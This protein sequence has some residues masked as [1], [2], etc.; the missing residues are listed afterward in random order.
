M[1]RT[2]IRSPFPASA[3]RP[4]GAPMA[5]SDTLK[6]GEVGA[7][8][9]G[10]FYQY[11]R[12]G[13]W[14][15][16]KWPKKRG[17]P[18]SAAQSQAQKD[19]A[20]VCRAIKLTAAEVQMYARA[21]AAGTPML[22]RD[23]MMAAL[24]GN[25]PTIRTYS[26]KVIKPMANKLLSSTVLDAIAWAPGDLLVRG[27]DTWDP[28]PKGL[29]GQALM[30]KPDGSGL[31]WADVQ[32]AGRMQG[33]LMPFGG[34]ENGSSVNMRFLCVEL[35]ENADLNRVY[36]QFRAKLGDVI[37]MWVCTLGATGRV[38]AHVHYDPAFAV[39]TGVMQMERYEFEPA[40]PF[41]AGQRI[42]IVFS[43][44]GRPSSYTWYMRGTAGYPLSMPFGNYTGGGAAVLTVPEI[45]TLI[46][47]TR[48]SYN[49]I[50]VKFS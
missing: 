41:S 25:G 27:Q 24:Y 32:S 8:L 4:D 29:A 34:S 46:T 48:S 26:G 49:S 43:V 3:L 13:K 15:T 38:D 30:V 28:L 2:P 12:H 22:P 19:F 36:F 18:K 33:Y 45:N 1:G 5:L 40:L 35:L 10:Q 42:A 47:P 50:G 16:A 17:K 39:A 6:R 11:Q 21:N 9:K 20:A 23:A 14:V 31:E 7:S 37:R 44:A